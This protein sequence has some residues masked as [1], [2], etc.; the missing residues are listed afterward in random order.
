MCFQKDGI[1]V[2][3]NVG[4]DEARQPVLCNKSSV[5]CFN[6]SFFQTDE[7]TAVVSSIGY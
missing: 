1:F 3:E 5:L 6:I 7:R 2:R 4:R